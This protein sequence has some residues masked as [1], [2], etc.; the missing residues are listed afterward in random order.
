MG[1]QIVHPL[2]AQQTLLSGLQAAI[3]PLAA[4]RPAGRVEQIDVVQYCKRVR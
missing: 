2:E 3:R 1:R 4:K